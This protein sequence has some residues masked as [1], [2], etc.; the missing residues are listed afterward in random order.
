MESLG[1]VGAMKARVYVWKRMGRWAVRGLAV[2]GGVSVLGVAL[3][4]SGIPWKVHVFLAEDGVKWE[5]DVARWTPTHILVLGGSGI[6]GESGL[7]R[8]WYAAETSKA[9][10]AVPVWIALP[11]AEGERDDL[12]AV[13]YMEELQL[14]GID[15]GRCEPRACG[16]NTHAQAVGLVRELEGGGQ[17][18]VLV[19]TSPEHVRRACL[20]VRRAARDA[21]ATIE[22][23]GLSAEN[24][25]LEDHGPEMVVTE[26]AESEEK[27]TGATESQVSAPEAL[28]YEFWNHARYSLDAAREC[29]ALAYYRVKG[30]I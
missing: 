25:S 11:C 12:A 15:A 8:L 27:A 17:A 4:F 1:Y 7:M 3:Q 2:L 18:R 23:R 29:V 13:A 28:R 10:P 20:T 9:C 24:L 6:P 14:R 21:G 5:S 19:V 26:T 22:V 30:W 16:E